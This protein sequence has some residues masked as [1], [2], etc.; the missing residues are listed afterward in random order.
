MKTYILRHDSP[1]SHEYAAVCAESCDKLGIEWEYFEGYCNMSTLSAWQD[2]NIVPLDN[3]HDKPLNTNRERG[4]LCTASHVAIW[5][6]I[7]K[8][9]DMAVILEH[10]AVML[11]RFEMTPPDMKFVALGY[12]I[13]NLEDYDHVSAGPPKDIVRMS[14]HKGTHAYAINQ[15]TAKHLISEI[16]ENGGGLGCVDNTWFAGKKTKVTMSIT[17]PICAVAWLRQ[18]TIWGNSSKVNSTLIESYKQYGPKK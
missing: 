7:A 15:M 4:E 14:R 2:L 5:K 16:V 18:S 17:D 11:H 13:N 3:R 9:D 10:D 12:K 8:D 6:K 1:V